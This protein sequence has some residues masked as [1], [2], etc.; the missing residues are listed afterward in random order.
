MV[1][2][3]TA[4]TPIADM[5]RYGRALAGRFKKLGLK[6][7]G[8]LLMHPPARYEDLS[9]VK[10]IAD[11]MGG[12][13]V[14]IQAT[15]EVIA[16]RRTPQKR[17]AI[18]EAVLSDCSGKITAVW[19]RQ[20]YITNSLKAGTK[21]SFAGKVSAEYGRLQLI[22]PIYE[23]AE[24][25]V[26]T[27]RIIPIYPT[28]ANLTQKHI[29]A[30]VDMALPALAT[31]IDP[32]P[33][34]MRNDYGLGPLA[35]ALKE[36][37]YP[38]SD[39][40]LLRARRRLQ[41][42]ELLMHQ[43]LALRIKDEVRRETGIP[44]KF[45]EKRTQEFVGSLPFTL[46]D[47]Q[48]KA[49]WAILKDMEKGEPM[50]R[51]LD[52]DVGSGKTAV[53]A[54]AAVNVAA[55]GGQTAIMAPTEVLAKQHFETLSRFL[56]SASL[57]LRTNAYKEGDDGAALIVGTH[58]LLEESVPMPQ[59]CLAVV[60]E[61]HRFGVEQRAGLLKKRGD[62][63]LPHLL[64]MT[65]TPIPRTLHLALYGD[66][67]ISLLRMKPKNRL[68]IATKILKPD[69]YG[70]AYRLVRSEIAAGRQAFFV[71]PVIEASDTT[72]AKSATELFSHLS[73]EVFPDLKIGLLH[74]RMKSAEKEKAMADFA[75][76]QIQI[77]V[78]TAVIEVGI[79]IPNATVMVI[80]GAERFGLAQLHQFRGRV[81]R[82]EY[83]SYCFA[84]APDGPTSSRLRAFAECGDGF[85][86]A[87]RDLALRGPGELFG[88]RQSGIEEMK[89]AT[90]TDLR[91]IEEARE[92]AAGL[93]ALGRDLPSA[94]LLA[95][96][97]K[98]YEQA[99]H[100]E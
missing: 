30:M 36:I 49:A 89:F 74:G 78:A 71:S 70:E 99:L 34:S 7:A 13:T 25:G 52:G 83:C 80:T 84:F 24:R 19:F 42:D 6:T 97:I 29:R 68:P 98:K 62:G 56:P 1:E 14:T 9:E 58:A 90:F 63:K 5:G 88:T 31:I 35:V 33:E 20:P 95:E 26:H 92:A 40:D 57:A 61:Q 82:S 55:S 91:S 50:H 12:E 76:G 87:E 66:L 18:T 43:L 73:K 67:D 15:V 100:L 81:G 48:R 51:L 41:F 77:L 8:D 2:A 72:G 17:M 16:N 65:A 54:I 44:I 69:R 37:H 60:D 28:T 22:S 94:P 46:T 39:A 85:D 96:K 45:A 38:T 86:L 11:L 93:L 4:E 64:S 75:A 32:L 23:P 47:D 10:K 3:M 79:D 21:A 27:G 53:A 59:L